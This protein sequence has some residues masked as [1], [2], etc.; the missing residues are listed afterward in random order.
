MPQPP[1]Q[2]FV[3]SSPWIRPA[4]IG[5]QDG[6]EHLAAVLGGRRFVDLVQRHR[7][8]ELVEGELFLTFTTAA[9]ICIC[10]PF[11]IWGMV[12]G[13]SRVDLTIRLCDRLPFL[14][15]AHAAQRR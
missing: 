8:D 4:R 11:S 5:G 14:L 9:E 15:V 6:L 10:C 12:R 3:R 13:A 1:S 2:S 7:C